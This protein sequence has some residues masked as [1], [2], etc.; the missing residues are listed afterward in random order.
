MTES[1][2]GRKSIFGRSMVLMAQR[3]SPHLSLLL[4]K[5][6]K[7]RKNKK[8]N[9]RINAWQKYKITTGFEPGTPRRK[10]NTIATELKIILPY[11]VLR[12]CI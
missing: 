1:L 4:R 7:V 12:Y 2:L 9:K 11:A 6:S 3:R 10:A 5:K 8:R